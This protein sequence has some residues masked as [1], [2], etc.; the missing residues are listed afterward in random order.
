[1]NAAVKLPAAE[2]SRDIEFGFVG[3]FSVAVPGLVEAP[4]NR[5]A[6]SP[7]T[8]DPILW[9]RGSMSS[10]GVFGGTTG[11]PFLPAAGVGIPGVF[12]DA[13]KWWGKPGGLLRL[14]RSVFLPSGASLPVAEQL[15]Y[16]AWLDTV[17]EELFAAR[18]VAV[19]TGNASSS[20][21][22]LC[23]GIPC[24]YDSSG[25]LPGN[26]LGIL[27]LAAD[28]R[29]HLYVGGEHLVVTLGADRFSVADFGGSLRGGYFELT[30]QGLN[31]DTG[32]FDDLSGPWDLYFGPVDPP[33]A[34][35]DR[36]VAA[37]V[38]PTAQQDVA[39]LN[40][41]AAKFRRYRHVVAQQDTTVAWN[42]QDYP[43]VP[44]AVMDGLIGSSEYLARRVIAAGSAVAL[45]ELIR[46]EVEAFWPAP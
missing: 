30:L 1:M 6:K 12:W 23:A 24:W 11:D 8:R 2:S 33:S 27:A 18:N 26:V 43:F 39:T 17:N 9:T 14:P 21:S 20:T 45:Q 37:F 22:S 42:G 38:Y 34:G 41:G 4:A 19:V 35:F 15:A 44:D 10:A 46:E 16:F 3:P 40:R 28:T 7:G 5:V 32:E 36:S 25:L 13:P 29:E 31:P